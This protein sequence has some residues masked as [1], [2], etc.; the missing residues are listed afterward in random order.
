MCF[1]NTCEVVWTEYNLEHHV[2]WWTSLPSTDIPPSLRDFCLKVEFNNKF[3]KCSTTVVATFQ[4]KTQTDG[5]DAPLLRL[6][7]Q[8]RSRPLLTLW[9]NQG[10]VFFLTV[11]CFF[12]HFLCLVSWKKQLLPTHTLKFSF[13]YASQICFILCFFRVCHMYNNSLHCLFLCAF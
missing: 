6:N 5:K 2:D 12:F 11:H 10:S 9:I 13:F 8:L 4:M 7:C 3:F 1:I